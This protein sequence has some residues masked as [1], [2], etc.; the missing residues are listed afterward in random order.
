[1]SDREQIDD[2]LTA[3]RRELA[4]ARVGGW[5]FR[6]RVLAE[7]EDHLRYLVRSIEE[8][9][10]ERAV[11]EREAMRRFG[12]PGDLAR[13]WLADPVLARGLAGAW[14]VDWLAGSSLGCLAGLALALMAGPLVGGLLA[15]FLILPV[16]GLAVGTGLGLAQWVL[17]RTAFG[18]PLRW[19]AAT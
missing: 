9:G 10:A 17:L 18:S 8:E 4:R 16:I 19:V 15:M 3:Y 2:Y 1:M 5:L 13:A 7:A 12:D 11:A 14:R 6:Q